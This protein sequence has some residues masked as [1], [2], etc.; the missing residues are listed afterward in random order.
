MRMRSKQSSIHRVVRA[1]RLMATTRDF[2]F[3]KLCFKVVSTLEKLGDLISSW[4]AVAHISILSP[5]SSPEI[6]DELPLATE[7]I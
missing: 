3:G 2:S 5:C 6:R 7:N 4:S 1:F